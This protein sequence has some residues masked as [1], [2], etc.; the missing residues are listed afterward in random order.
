M[1]MDTYLAEEEK[2]IGVVTWDF[3]K[4][5]DT[6]SNSILLDKMSNL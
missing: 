5:F 1:D 6:V 4:T 2:P 3:S